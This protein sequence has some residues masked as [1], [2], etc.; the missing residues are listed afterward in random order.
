MIK[1][2]KP[3]LPNNKELFSAI[4]KVLESEYLSFG[5]EVFKF[6][7]EFEEITSTKNC[8]AVNSGTSAIHLALVLSNV[9][10]G[11]EVISTA[12]TAE[13]TNMAI[14]MTG[15]KIRYADISLDD[16]NIDPKSIN[17]K[18]NKNTRAIIAVD[19]S[20][21]PVNIDEI[22][23]IS[24][25][26]NLPV[27]HDVAHS[28]G[29][30]YRNKPAANYFD[31]TT[32]SF[33]AIKHLTTFDG[34]MLIVKDEIKYQR[35]NKMRWFGFDKSQ[36]RLQNNI[37][38]IGFKYNMNNVNATIGRI[39]LKYIKELIEKH[40]FNANYLTKNLSN[41]KKIRIL[42][43]PTYSEPSYWMYTILSQQ[44]ESIIKILTK[45]KIQ[46]GKVH[47]RNDKHYFLNDFNEKLPNL[48][49]Y[50]N[51]LVHIPCGWWLNKSDLDFMIEILIKFDNDRFI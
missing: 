24:N 3:Y 44:S 5:E 16:G 17:K 41:L 39:Q 8:L 50:Y 42:K 20:G 35:A 14:K 1:L 51:Q 29:S 19:Y 40:K 43:I 13:P 15:A 37:E 12:L 48:D 38:E 32:Y 36:D 23:K 9:G 27:I 6:E 22:L 7:K 46:C 33:Q 34:G 10:Q 30:N 31:F 25:K 4:K 45:N 47:L 26:Y 49:K 2:F 28:F 11:D 18:I 21:I